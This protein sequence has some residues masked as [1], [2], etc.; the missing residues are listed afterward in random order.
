MA[1][2]LELSSRPTGKT[3]SSKRSA[4]EVINVDSSH[5]RKAA[6]NMMRSNRSKT[7]RSILYREG[8][9]LLNAS[10]RGN[11]VAFMSNDRAATWGGGIAH[12]I[13]AQ[14]P[15][16]QAKFR[17]MVTERPETLM[18]GN[19]ILVESE[20]GQKC[21]VLIAQK[22]YGRSAVPRIRYAALEQALRRLA[23]SAGND[24]SAV[25]MPA[26]GTGAAGGKWQRISELIERTLC[27]T[28]PVTVFVLP[29]GQ[30]ARRT[31]LHWSRAVTRDI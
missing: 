17:R 28:A 27:R 30:R 13:A 25:H 15:D 1:T 26:I 10:A 21:A 23:Q 9:V 5:G 8:D 4:S 19:C 7:S 2:V 3:V 12:Q 31:P 29:R 11:I 16:V 22:G 18:L 6:N 14:F 20:S 24:S